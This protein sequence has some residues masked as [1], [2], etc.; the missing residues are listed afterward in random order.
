[1]GDALITALGIIL[2]YVF[3]CIEVL[4]FYGMEPNSVIRAI[5]LYMGF[6]IMLFGIYHLMNDLKGL[7]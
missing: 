2:I 7:V 1:M 4:G 6:P 3:V 5:E